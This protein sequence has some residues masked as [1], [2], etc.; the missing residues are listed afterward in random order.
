MTIALNLFPRNDY[1]IPVSI[2]DADGVAVDIR[3]WSITF[4]AKQIANPQL[5]NS[6]A[7]LLYTWAVGSGEAAVSGETTMCLTKDQ[8][9]LPIREYEC[10]LQGIDLYYKTHTIDV[11]ILSISRKVNTDDI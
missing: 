1:D 4:T 3:G 8:L 11:G 6:E 5:P 10:D 7:A 2:V 9:D